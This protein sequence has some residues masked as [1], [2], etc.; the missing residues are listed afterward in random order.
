MKRANSENDDVNEPYISGAYINNFLEQTIMRGNET[1]Q[2][3][4]SPLPPPPPPPQPQK[5]ARRRLQ[6]RKPYQEKLLNMAEARREIVAALKLHRAT[7]KQQPIQ[8]R[9]RLD[10]PAEQTSSLNPRIY[11]SNPPLLNAYPY[12]DRS[13]LCPYCF[14]P[15]PA[16]P[17]TPPPPP[18]DAGFLKFEVPWQGLGLKLDVEEFIGKPYSVYVDDDAPPS[19]PGI[20]GGL[21]F[22]DDEIASSPFDEEVVEFPTWLSDDERGLEKQCVVDLQQDTALPCLEIEEIDGMDGDWLA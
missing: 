9:A 19:P 4:E 18:P 17:L 11:A 5:K 21:D 12:A 2:E 14:S 8:P 10:F 16:Q 15:W 1:T 22:D 20:G 13:W 7:T 3:R 6:A